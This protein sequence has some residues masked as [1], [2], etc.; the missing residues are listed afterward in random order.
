[1][2]LAMPG[3]I[4]Q[5]CQPNSVL[6]LM[7]YIEDYAS[8]EGRS[9]GMETIARSLGSM[10]NPAIKRQTEERLD[11]IKKGERDIFF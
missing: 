3:D 11:R 5:F 6:T 4:H 8:E 2:D 9:L 1:M 7:E 10:E